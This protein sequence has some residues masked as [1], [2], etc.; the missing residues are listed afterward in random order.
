M[1][2][3]VVFSDGTGQDGGQG[4]NTNVYKLFNLILDRSEEQISFYDKGL[5]TGWR[6]ASGNILGRG[7]AKNVRECYEFIFQN[8]QNGDN[9]FLFGFSRGA[10]TVRSL[11]GFIHNFGILPRSRI[12]LIKRAWKIYE[13]RN[14][15]KRK[16]KA[17]E[18]IKNNHTMWA[19]IKFLGVWDTVAALG[20]PNSKI[21]WMLDRLIPHG[22]HDYKLSDSV[23][24]A[25]HA[26]AIDDRWKAFHP[27]LFNPLDSSGQDNQK[28]KQTLKQVWFMGMHTDVGGGYDQKFLSDIPLE[29][30]VQNAVKHGLLL[31]NDPRNKFAGICDPNQDGHMH[32]SIDKLWKKAAF[33]KKEREWRFTPEKP[34]IHE[35]VTLRI[36]SI[37]NESAGGYNPWIK[38]LNPNVEPWISS[39]D[40]VNDSMF[41]KLDPDTLALL[42]KWRK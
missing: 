10:A 21:D 1:K 5:G 34:T 2:N 19:E 42:S 32:N 18:F 35:S 38:S 8:Y 29:W 28:P 36:A 20:V 11:S 24:N 14:H 23:L 26:V 4:H 27:I 9:I 13:I 40:I 3:I 30:M 33:K 22:F 31:Y 17:K 16:K 37:D 6:K 39:K 12:E 7:F 15:E 25:Y 41:N